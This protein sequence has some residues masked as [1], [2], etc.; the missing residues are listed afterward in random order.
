[1][2]VDLIKLMACY[3]NTA[4]DDS[5]KLFQGLWDRRNDIQKEMF[6]R[7]GKRLR[8]MVYGDGAFK[9]LM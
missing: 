4:T 9:T 1:M 2:A 8:V 6:R 7:T 3:S 5:V